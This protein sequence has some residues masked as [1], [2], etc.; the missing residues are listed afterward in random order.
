MK[1]PLRDVSPDLIKGKIY[2]KTPIQPFK[3]VKTGESKLKIIRN[4]K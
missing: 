4:R 1:T 2:I 3:T